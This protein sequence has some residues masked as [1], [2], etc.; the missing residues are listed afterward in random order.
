MENVNFDIF[1][2]MLDLSSALWQLLMPRT[3]AKERGE[4][5]LI[6]LKMSYTFPSKVFEF[7][8]KLTL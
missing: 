3:L 4:Q 5:I 7:F 2:K 1:L 8:E 6:T